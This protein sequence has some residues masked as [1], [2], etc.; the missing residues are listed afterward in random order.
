MFFNKIVK[1]HLLI[2]TLGISIGVLIS[3]YLMF[4]DPELRKFF[5]IVEVLLSA[6]CGILII[7]L[8]YG[9]VIKLDKLF[10]W[11]TQITNR[12]LIGLIIH[13]FTGIVIAIGVFYLYNLIIINQISFAEVYK[14]MMIKFAILWFIIVQLFSIVYFALFSYYSYSTLQIQT[15]KLER[16]RIDLQLDALKSQLSPHFLFNSFNTISSLIY[17]DVNKAEIFIRR[18]SKMYHYTLDSYQ[19]K[20]I[21]FEKE[22]EF[23]KSYIY[24]Q[25]T[26]F[27][28]MFKCK[29]D[30]PSSI[31]N[32]KVPPLA[33]QMLIE[34]A[35][36]HNLMSEKTPLNVNITFEDD[37]IS[38][39]NNIT[40]EPRKVPSFKIGLNNISARYQLLS[41]KEIIIVNGQSFI[42]KIPVIR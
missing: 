41:N 42:V 32:T 5:S 22:L 13:F 11:E 9:I 10:P 18:L 28:K 21:S 3:Y 33:L 34:N 30:L 14:P 19:I 40:E 23:V 1:K 15:V 27:E 39:E 26:R 29:I 4:N 37:Y 36:K 16:K 35:V 20:L 7:Y 12:L 38:V 31:N 8:N 25:E 24:L 17:K 6:G 2:I